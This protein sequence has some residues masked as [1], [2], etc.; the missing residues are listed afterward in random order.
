MNFLTRILGGPANTH[1]RYDGLYWAKAGELLAEGTMKPLLAVLRFYDDGMVASATF[2]GEANIKGAINQVSKWFSRA[3]C[4]F[5]GNYTMS[6]GKLKFTITNEHS[7]L[8]K[9]QGPQTC[10]G[11]GTVAMDFENMRLT[12]GYPHAQGLL[13]DMLGGGEASFTFFA[14]TFPNESR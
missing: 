6:G 7:D 8:Q 1:I 13:R 5:L 3:N 9:S 12:L 2:V 10:T 14:S 4:N 11:E